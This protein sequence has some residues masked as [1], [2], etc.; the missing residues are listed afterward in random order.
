[1]KGFQRFQMN[2]DLAFVIGG[3]AAIDI[4]GA[5]LRIKGGRSPKIER[6]GGLHV[7][8][9]IEKDGR[10]TGRFERFG[11]NERMKIGGDDLYRP[12]PGGTKVVGDPFCGALDV[13]L[14]LALR[15]DG[16]N[17]KK[18]AK[19]SEMLLAPTFDQFSKV[20]IRPS[21]TT[22]RFQNTAG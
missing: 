17:A 8:V 21:G 2:V 12:E 4:S 13:W 10:F 15:A 9:A 5:S 22:I 3:A 6:F 19:L 18:L 14:V 16:R 11:I 7:V 1:M 20:H